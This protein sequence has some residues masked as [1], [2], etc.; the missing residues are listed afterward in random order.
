MWQAWVTS[1]PM[2]VNMMPR[3]FIYAF[4]PNGHFNLALQ[5]SFGGIMPWEEEQTCWN[6]ILVCF[7]IRCVL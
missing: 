3:L 7:A 4:T 1:I 2:Q 6:P 5:H